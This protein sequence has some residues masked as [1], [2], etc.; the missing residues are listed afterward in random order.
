MSDTGF[1]PGQPGITQGGFQEQFNVLLTDI[2]ALK[3]TILN[4]QW[5]INLAT[6]VLQKS[7]LTPGFW[8]GGRDTS[9]CRAVCNNTATLI[10]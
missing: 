9:V 2:G 3:Q 5:Q 4:A 10:D 6:S 1:Q 7:E 8:Q